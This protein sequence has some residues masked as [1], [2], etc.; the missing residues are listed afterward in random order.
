MKLLDYTLPTPAENLALDEALLVAAEQDAGGEVLR[1][2]E[3]PA[4]AV[5]L[6]TGGAVSIDVNLA[7]CAAD[8]VPVLRRAS[9]G[10]TVLVGP[11]CLCFG[12][13]L[14]YDRAP[15]LNE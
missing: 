13:V 14:S 11:R 7:A 1:L 5:V 9:G 4:V 10:G 12:L 8:G 15:G 2:W 6:G 3:S